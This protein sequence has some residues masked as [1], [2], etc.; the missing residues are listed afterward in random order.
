MC[1]LP[2]PNT[3]AVAS[4]GLTHTCALS[5][6]GTL[7][8][9]SS[10]P[11]LTIA[12]SG[13]A[14]TSVA[15]ADAFTC[16]VSAAN[17][18]LVCFG[19]IAAVVASAQAQASAF[20]I[21]LF[22]NASY[23][24]IRGPFISSTLAAGAAFACAL[25]QPSGVP[26]CFGD[27]STLQ[28]AAPASTPLSALACGAAHACG[29]S[30]AS[31]AAVCWGNDTFSQV[32]GVAA[33]VAT[34]FA[35]LALT[36]KSS[37][38]LTV[39]G[40]L[41]CWGGLAALMDFAIRSPSPPSLSSVTA[42][43]VGALGA[44]DTLCAQSTPCATA[45]ASLGCAQTLACATLAGA[46]TALVSN[47]ALRALPV[48]G[49]AVLASHTSA[50]LAIPS[51]LA[52]GLL[53]VGALNGGTA[54][55][56]VAFSAP[57]PGMTLMW[58]ENTGVVLSN[59]VIDGSAAPGCD[60]ALAVRGLY[61]YANNVTFRNL[62][63]SRAVVSATSGSAATASAAPAGTS[64][65]ANTFE[66]NTVA[67]SNN[68]APIYVSIWAQPAVGI[69]GVTASHSTGS[70]AGFLAV[71]GAQHVI[72][73]RSTLA[74]FA[75]VSTTVPAPAGSL[76][77]VPGQG[78][79]VFAFNTPLVS[80]SGVSITNVSSAAGGAALCVLGS[81][82]MKPSIVLTDVAMTGVSS[83]GSGGAISV[84]LDAV[85][86]SAGVSILLLRVNVSRAN[87]AG[88]G[89]ALY[90]RAPGLAVLVASSTFDDTQSRGGSGG[91]I[92]V[93]AA[94]SFSVSAST[95]RNVTSA[96][97]GGALWATS[98]P[99][100]ALTSSTILGG[101]SSMGGGGGAFVARFSSLAL[102][103]TL[104]FGC[105]SAGSIGGGG[106]A[107]VCNA[108]GATTCSVR[109]S[110]STLSSNKASGG[111]GGGLLATSASS[112]QELVL[113]V[114]DSTFANNSAFAG[115]GGGV[116][117]DST[118]S[119]SLSG[120]TLSGNSAMRGGGLYAQP[121]AGVFLPPAA[122]VIEVRLQGC[123]TAG[124]VAS[125]SGGGAYVGL[126]FLDVLQSSFS[127]NTA[128]ASGGG[129]VAQSSFLALE[130]GAVFANN[131]AVSFNGGGLAV[132][133][134]L[135]YGFIS[136]W[137]PGDA[138]SGSGGP[139]FSGNRAGQYGGAV[140]VSAT[141]VAL[142]YVLL[143]NNSAGAAGGGL[144]I[145]SVSATSAAVLGPLVA[146]GNVASGA[147]GGAISALAAG[148][149]ISACQ[150]TAAAGVSAAGHA[151]WIKGATQLAAAKVA[152]AGAAAALL[153]P[154]LATLTASA[155]SASNTSL[156]SA[157]APFACIF[158]GNRAAGGLGGDVLVTQGASD[159]ASFSL[160]PSAS[161]ASAAAGGGGS[162]ALQSLAGPASI[163][164]ASFN[165]SSTGPPAGL[166][167]GAGLGG[168]LALLQCSSFSGA[169]LS[170]SGCAASFGGALYVATRRNDDSAAAV[171]ALV[172]TGL[173]YDANSAAQGGGNEFFE[174]GS[175]ITRLGVVRQLRP[176][177]AALY[178]PGVA[179]S[180]RALSPQPSP[181][182]TPFK[183]GSALV[184]IGSVPIAGPLLHVALVDAFG[185]AVL[186][187]NST[188]CVLTGV[189]ND[190]G[191]ALSLI[192]V[193][194]ASLSG[195]VSI[196][197]L[198]VQNGPGISALLT[199]ACLVS[200]AGVSPARPLPLLTAPLGTSIVAVAWS[201]ASLAAAPIYFLSSTADA[202]KPP[203]A[204][205][206][207][208]LVDN[209]GLVITAVSVSCSLAVVSGVDSTGAATSASLVGFGS[210][211]ATINGV[212]SFL[213]SLQANSNTSM[214][215]T[216]S[217]TWISGDIVT[218]AS[219][220]AVR[221]YA[222]SLLWAGGGGGGGGG[223]GSGGCACSAPGGNATALCSAVCSQASSLG[224]AG[225]GGGSLVVTAAGS[226]W[227]VSSSGAASRLHASLTNTS[228]AGATSA[229]P[230]S[231]N[232]A[233]LQALSPAPA[234]VLVQTIAQGGNATVLASAPPR[235]CTL[236]VA[237]LGSAAYA[238]AALVA[239][240]AGTSLTSSLNTNAVG[241]PQQQMTSGAASFEGVGLRG[242]GFA[243]A[244]PLS[245]SCPWAT[246]EVL[247]S[248]LLLVLV[249]PLLL[250]WSPA[251]LAA[252][253]LY[254]VACT[255]AQAFVTTQPAVL[256]L[257]NGA[258]G[259]VQASAPPVSCTVSV[260]SAVLG[261]TGQATS[262]S[263]LGATT[264]TT[265]A[266]VASFSLGVSGASN[267]SLLLTASCTWI[268][269]DIVTVASPLA[270]RTYALALL[271]LAGDTCA[272][273]AGSARGSD[274]SCAAACAAP[275]ATVSALAD[276]SAV[277][278]SGAGADAMQWLSA[279]N[280]ANVSRVLTGGITS[281]E[282]A[283]LLD[284]PSALPSSSDV[285]TLQPLKSAPTAAVVRMLADGSAPIVLLAPSLSCFLA[286]DSR[287]SAASYSADAGNA[288][289]GLSFVSAPAASV[290]G[291]S[292]AS[293]GGG[294]AA[295][296]A[297][298]VAGA[299]FG[300]AVPLAAQCS[301]LTSETVTSPT[302][303]V[304]TSRLRVRVLVAP[305]A[306]ALPSSSTQ[307]FLFSPAPAVV[308]EACLAANCSAANAFAPFTAAQLACTAHASPVDPMSGLAVPDAA[309]QLQGTLTATTSTASSVASF[310]ALAVVGPFGA[311]FATSFACPW[312]SGD[313]VA[314]SSPFTL[315]PAVSVAWAVG[316]ANSSSFAGNLSAPPA[317]CL[318]NTPMTF[319]VQ[320]SYALPATPAAP[321][322]PNLTSWTSLSGS[323]GSE[324]SCSLS[325]TVAGQ[326]ILLTGLA[327]A[328]A[329]PTGLLVFVGVALLP[330]LP[331][332]AADPPQSVLLTAS[333]LARGNALPSITAG[334]AIEVLSVAVLQAPP[335]A[336]LPASVSAPLPFSPTVSVAILTTTGG[337]LASESAAT[338]TVSV[339]AQAFAPF[340]PESQQQVSLLG[341]VRSSISAGVAT[342]PG[343][344]IS[345]PLG[346]SAQL[347]FDCTRSAGG[348]VFPATATVI[349][350]VVQASLAPPPPALWQLY[351]TPMPLNAVLQQFTP[352][353][354][355]GWAVA[356]GSIPRAALALS[357]SLQL[358]S[359]AASGLAISSSSP[360]AVGATGVSNANGSVA[361]ALALTG[362]AGASDNVTVL[363]GVAG[364]TFSTPS[365]RV[366]IETVI[367][368]AVV[369]PP[370]VWLPSFASALTP[371][372]PVPSVL[373][374]TLH[375]GLPVDAREAACQLSVASPNASV[376]EPP[377]AGYKLEP[378]VAALV[379]DASSGTASGGG[380]GANATAAA[381]EVSHSPIL[382][383]NALVK[384]S[385]W[386]L[387]L[388]MSVS[389]RRAQGD[390]T[391]PLS[392]QL[393][394]VDA[395]AEF[396]A[397]PPASVVSQT[398]FS[399]QVRLFDR[400]A[401]GATLELDNVTLC[402]MSVTT[403][404]PLIV[405][406]N[407]QV[408]AVAGV[409]SF[410]GISLAAQSGLQ[411]QGLVSCALGSL[412]FPRAL[413]WSIA[414]KPCGPGTAPAGVGGYTCA[415]CSS[416]TYSDGGAGVT[417]CTPCPGQGVSCAGGVLAL[418]PGFARTQDG[419]VTVSAS[420]EL[421]PCWNA[422]GCF[423]NLNASD[424]NRAAN[425]THSC[426]EGY[427]G[428]ICGVCSAADGF[429]Q[430]SGTCVPCGSMLANLAVVALLPFVVA[431]LV[432]WISLYRK[433]EASADSQVLTRITLTYLQTV[434][435][436][437]S[438][439]FARGTAEFRALFGF[440]TAVGDSPLSITPVQCSLRLPYYARFGIT[441]S[442]PFSLAVLVL[443]TNLAALAIARMRAGAGP[444]DV[445]ARISNGGG[446]GNG[447]GEVGD[448]SAAA[449]AGVGLAAPAR[450]LERK[451][452]AKL[453]RIEGAE[454]LA[455]AAGAAGAGGVAGG[456]SLLAL[457]RA[458][459]HRFF[460]TQAWVAPVIFVLNL[461]YSSL[462]TTS[463][464]MFNCMPYSVAGVTYLAQD[465]SVTCYDSLHNGFRG[466]A[467]LLIA[468]FGAGFP[469]LFAALLWRH[470]AELHT[471]D[472]F[473]RLGFLYDGYSVKRGM[474]AWESVV[475][476]RKAAIVM[477]GSLVKDAYRQIFASVSLLVVV[478][479]LQA[480]F[481]PY[482]KRFF[483][484]FESAALVT[485]MLTQLVCVSR[486]GER[487]RACA[488]KSARKRER[489][490]QRVR[491]WSAQACVRK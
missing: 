283:A 194:Y 13:M 349:V 430:V 105:L 375:G 276:A 195:I 435:T 286:V 39:G 367:V 227:A 433:V 156:A 409:A 116:F 357:C 230:S 289:S 322:P 173:T 212:A 308:I 34:T 100:V 165:G 150:W 261:A 438:I 381:Y 422:R 300:A 181:Y 79:A 158:A 72:M 66:L 106:L 411:V 299:G 148:G 250:Q 217:C 384:T 323:P 310:A 321:S 9:F 462:T 221:T 61:N 4:P 248:Q 30:L 332:S 78:S 52:P 198:T 468:F 454:A 243:A 171:A 111:S 471:P 442:L 465:L 187:G 317:A 309:I 157:S 260:A 138:A 277:F 121:N 404:N 108:A 455:S 130:A 472:V 319:G 394:I 186:S 197:P 272:C 87:A 83:G 473:A 385:A 166:P 245:A 464:G 88:S 64:Y 419:A 89:G 141:S 451:S 6:A 389:C 113:N 295:F 117:F 59:L 395:D 268:S 77:G 70:A 162:L 298:G 351:N 444:A 461:S 154:L 32:S 62:R 331:T 74:N 110:S 97:D 315:L 484:F 343:L 269:G 476:V 152:G 365:V 139:S 364:Q 42:I 341:V 103:R 172:V 129:V 22:S 253:P 46:V 401:G 249:P 51:W 488:R 354:A 122:S 439:Y 429:A 48:R 427:G 390:N 258:T 410:L 176:S 285:L 20:A 159:P 489:T 374:K 446:S 236:A 5:A 288:G 149:A 328:R 347:S 247:Q 412:P 209:S 174:T 93:A 192:S 406:Q 119:V 68:S 400:G 124:N 57:S 3:F 267:A 190:T 183:N 252:A 65:A 184:V 469:L 320:L 486:K 21:V 255:A 397:A 175:G 338:C 160:G 131:T 425:N 424:R 95:L 196:F 178:G 228:S 284:A 115:N 306:A 235:T 266:G 376:L 200:A 432:V 491:E 45:P 23:A 10:T 423:V 99:S 107:A 481:Q 479:F 256:Q 459:L 251:T 35:S 273:T 337:V 202:P 207:A 201:A 448:A 474:Y 216:A 281:L 482:E 440:T 204:P 25:T 128:A 287:Y 490:G 80:L 177:S 437:S 143:L 140:F 377:L 55:P 447:G 135:G 417:E 240:P 359:P 441:V 483:N 49:I 403:D 485:I 86:V 28:L 312:S 188:T 208:N 229:L 71:W 153:T 237:A 91:A 314:A 408:R 333:C 293:S 31:G 109:L 318:Y 168:A 477:I 303:L 279:G 388:N 262:V 391:A 185:Q 372:S 307:L 428:P 11:A 339:V 2:S 325:G 102:S 458:D 275:G 170:F 386:G 421:H 27:N 223:G 294:R 263:L 373:L 324:L 8:C 238:A 407:G 179:T 329:S 366:A 146:A 114:S 379:V 350:D 356:A 241:A 344:S 443:L 445:A 380:G 265:V 225:F 326:P 460:S 226:Q 362:A 335:A 136:T 457:L 133:A 399:M 14:F 75:T 84:S 24:T 392:W 151:S 327:T 41:K 340:V 292:S 127:G 311:A 382:L 342:F 352:N 353:P 393:R 211:V 254:T 398:A 456:S 470:R 203:N 415:A 104:I 330:A 416:G 452:S 278:A 466:L 233:T 336:T 33:Y 90:V 313:V 297:A 73:T 271:W 346:A 163:S 161:V 15:S 414:M 234:L 246:G 420:T 487:E 450:K 193:T 53:I 164:G 167:T 40:V 118:P 36:S 369:A 144:F 302:L 371:F 449:A 426:L 290:V 43:T 274:P 370:T 387:K 37:C 112:V 301:W 478:L 101:S 257:V 480:T 334:T 282:G 12:P 210:T 358:Q 126:A 67:F 305:P 214:L 232:A 137:Q 368:V 199:L 18:S 120:C 96:G 1:V 361:F 98:V 123:T 453:R 69:I 436:L 434:G 467:G 418:L 304:R 475:M 402:T 345:A 244:V 405:L 169:N 291:E 85:F 94:S 383:T 220:L 264:S 17:A 206:V 360:G 29:V 142:S 180:P 56:V 215:L 16:A 218:V 82:V 7:A 44:S 191:A 348:V 134:G 132:L 296:A 413:P 92:A 38:G 147:G 19:S 396:L 50:P 81:G 47:P 231:L 145:D 205:I 155:A 259:Q 60:T 239:L 463:F 270:V 76:Y 219:P 58:V 378:A 431:A 26:L 182:L 355:A 189:R 280:G 316:P 242:S 125:V 54:A 363:C 224:G 222:L 213:P 63:C